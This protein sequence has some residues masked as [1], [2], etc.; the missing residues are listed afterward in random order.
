MATSLEN[1]QRCCTPIMLVQSKRAGSWVVSLGCEHDRAAL[2]NDWVRFP[3]HA[4]RRKGSVLTYLAPSLLQFEHLCAQRACHVPFSPSAPGT[5]CFHLLPPIPTH[6]HKLG[7]PRAHQ[8]R[9]QLIVS[10]D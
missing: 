7:A 10:L 4:L 6:L 3:V 9:G 8:H 2:H 1:L 5:S